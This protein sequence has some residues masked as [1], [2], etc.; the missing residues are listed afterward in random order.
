[1][2]PLVAEKEDSL[3]ILIVDKQG[4]IGPSLSEKLSA[5]TQVVFVSQKE[6][7]G[8]NIIFVPFVKK[9]PT[10]PDSNYSHIFVIDDA[11]PEIYESIPSFIKK[12]QNDG[13][14]LTI[15]ADLKNNKLLTG[16]IIEN[17][18]I[19]LIFFGDVVDK[20]LNK[21]SLAARFINQAKNR[22]R[23]DVP[24]DGMDIIYPIFFDDLILG[25]LEA[26]FGTSNDKIYYAFTKHGV[27]L[28]SLAHM[29][30]K[31]N[32]NVTVDFVESTGQEN[33]DIRSEGKYL[34][35]ENYPL[36]DKIKKIKIETFNLSKNF[37]KN[38][39]EDYSPERINKNTIAR[40]SFFFLVFFIS[41]P[42]I[43]TILF[44][45]FGNIF[46][47]S[48]KL[49]LKAANFDNA[50]KSVNVAEYFFSLSKKTSSLLVWE[51]NDFGLFK[52]LNNSI[53][54]EYKVSLGFSDFFKGV[55]LLSQNKTSQSVDYF[56]NFLIFLQSEKAYNNDLNFL[57]DDL[58]NFATA[59][60]DL[61]PKILGYD[62][63]KKYL[64]LFYNNT[65]INPTG[66]VI[67]AYGILTID[68][69]K[70]NNFVINNTDNADSLLKGHV[71]PPFPLRRHANIKNWYLRDS[72]FDPDFRNSASSSAFFLNL[73]T[74]D[75][76][77]GV[78]T[79][80]LN[81]VKSILKNN[82]SININK[83]NKTLT[84]DNIFQIVKEEEN[85]KNFI[86]NVFSELKNNFENK[87]ISYIALSKSLGDAIPQ[88]D[89]L[90]ASSEKNIQ[91]VFTVNG[92]SNALWDDR[93]D[94]PRL[95]NDFLGINEINLNK[96]NV[97]VKRKVVQDTK[98]SEDGNI[99]TN[100]VLEF[101]NSG[102]GIHKNYLRFILPNGITI[103][104]VKINNET[105]GLVNAITDPLIYED[106]NFVKPTGL[107]I[108]KYGQE[109]KSITGFLLDILEGQTQTVEINYSLAPKPSLSS[110]NNFSYSLKIFKQPGIDSYPYDFSLSYPSSWQILNFPKGFNNKNQTVSFSKEISRDT[111]LNL[112]FSKK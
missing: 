76:I 29:I 106:K 111:E 55:E 59:T 18:R 35:A 70:V 15:I 107:E 80:N 43:S 47:N 50:Q 93:Q 88:K 109:G 65:K 32:P 30:Q 54:R 82:G 56:K 94:T 34:L 75:K 9:F 41:L 86:A 37:D 45:F 2:N 5:D 49:S 74:G 17:K 48:A 6:K 83:D 90:F 4:L 105:Q 13:S 102:D 52:S 10:I 84:A 44:S 62:L 11:S 25:I 51:T 42:L 66:G 101:K 103:N 95:V 27:T 16:E 72:N 79:I 87:K 40:T 57:N 68:K 19:K 81:F 22:G 77:D 8:E 36:E 99:T 39:K 78:L 85:N 20:I 100:L 96:S 14:I 1:M 91:D 26:S 69:G 38:K 7:I 110:V 92:F 73:E 24:G 23:I 104:S 97:V 3:P 12:T 112:D 89:I 28:L 67:E 64:V 33:T 61:W 108:E 60:V 98:I 21:K 63:A 71:E 58:F 53:S 46:L 31:T